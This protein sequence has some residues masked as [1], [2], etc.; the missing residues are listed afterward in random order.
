MA[1]VEVDKRC[2]EAYCENDVV[3]GNLFCIEHLPTA[4]IVDPMRKKEQNRGSN[5]GDNDEK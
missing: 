3:P 5:E 1:K 2:V 4:R